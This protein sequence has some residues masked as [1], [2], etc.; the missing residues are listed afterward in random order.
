MP[1]NEKE[2]YR[3]AIQLLREGAVVA[4]PTDTVYG[5]VSVALDG[6][7][8][9]RV[10]D[11]KG[12]PGDQPLPLFVCSLEQARLVADMTPAAGKLAERFWPGALTI[13]LRRKP[14]FQTLAAAGG[15][16]IGVRVPD[17]PAI[18]EIAAQLG[19]LTATSANRSGAPE[20]RSAAEV[21]GQLGDAVDFI[22]D[23]PLVGG[24]GDASTVVDC[25][26]SNDVRVV[27]AGSIRESALRAILN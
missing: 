23:A 18:R 2:Q 10:F 13:V 1:L 3:R 14:S 15:E 5:L 25:R 6:A 9:R 8:V 11:A 20:A 26:N 16:T 17:D 4:M 27:R 12:R 21:R 22:V 19:P 24:G 7:A